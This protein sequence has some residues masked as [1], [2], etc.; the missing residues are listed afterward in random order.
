M[1]AKAALQAKDVFIRT[2]RPE[3]TS[4]IPT[5]NTYNLRKTAYRAQKP[6]NLRTQTATDVL[7]KLTRKKKENICVMACGEKVRSTQVNRDWTKAR[8]VTA[9]I[10]LEDLMEKEVQL[11][12]EYG[13]IQNLYTL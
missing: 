12:L 10:N 4:R 5:K 7:N 2:S 9:P 8:K 11:S 3:C 6:Y 1:Y 13:A